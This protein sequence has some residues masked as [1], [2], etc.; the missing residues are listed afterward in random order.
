MINDYTNGLIVKGVDFEIYRGKLITAQTEKTIYEISEDGCNAID[1]YGQEECAEKSLAKCARIGDIILFAPLTSNK[2]VYYDIRTGSANSLTIDFIDSLSE[3]EPRFW[4]MAEYDKYFFALGHNFPGIVKID[5][6]TMEYKV[7]TFP[8]EGIVIRDDVI[9]ADY[10]F[11][12]GYVKMGD[13][14]LFAFGKSKSL[15]KLNCFSNEIEIIPIISSIDRSLCIS[16][17]RGCLWITDS[18]IDSGC[19]A[20]WDYI[21]GTFKDIFLPT[22]GLYFAPVFYHNY[23]YIFPMSYIGKIYRINT[24]TF[25]VEPIEALDSLLTE[26]DDSIEI[27][28]AKMNVKKRKGYVSLVKMVDN[29]VQFIRFPDYTW[30]SYNVTS[31]E[32]DR[33]K[34]IIDDDTYIKAYTKKYL[35]KASGRGITVYEDDMTLENYITGIC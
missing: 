18:N 31:G 34:Y 25:Q 29:T 32:I 19:V 6:D 3:N 11:G 9:P 20:I 15:F 24:S 7:I 17:N 35:M 23:A 5:V 21:E 12:D 22:G 30:F 8:L 1:V 14:L 26:S 33:K 28:E 27:P 13:S 4:E 2:F 10:Y 16:E